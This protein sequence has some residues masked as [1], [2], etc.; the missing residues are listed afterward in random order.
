VT[1]LGVMPL[2]FLVP[3]IGATM[4]RFGVHT[5]H[6]R[7][8]AA[9]MA[10]WL[11]RVILADL[12]TP[13]TPR[14]NA[15]VRGLIG[16]SLRVASH[17][18]RRKPSGSSS[19]TTTDHHPARRLISS[20]NATMTMATGRCG[21]RH[22]HISLTL[23]MVTESSGLDLQTLSAARRRAQ[24]REGKS[25]HLAKCVTPTCSQVSRPNPI[26]ALQSSSSHVGRRGRRSIRLA[27]VQRHGRHASVVDRKS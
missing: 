18:V 20:W 3:D 21:I 9:V 14:A 22:R 23:L 27:R 6:A 13:E 25:E 4:R 1:L 26:D 24:A 11:V 19:A 15:S 10:L 7:A 5:R 17:H 8:R 12:P 2:A 16:H